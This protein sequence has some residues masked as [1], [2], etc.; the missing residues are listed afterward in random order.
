MSLRILAQLAAKSGWYMWTCDIT[1]AFIQSRY[2]LRRDVFFKPPKGV[3]VPGK[4]LKLLRPLYCLSDAGDHWFV[5]LSSHQ[6]EDL[7]IQPLYMDPELFFRFSKPGI[8]GFYYLPDA[9]AT[10]VDDNIHTGGP[11][12]LKITEGTRYKLYS[13]PITSRAFTFA[14]VDFTTSYDTVKISKP[15]AARLLKPLQSYCEFHDIKSRLI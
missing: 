4:Y 12:F 13:K 7:K 1:H 15:R 2:L 6:Q 14:G 5:T 9:T 8:G 11:Y 10:Y 3:H